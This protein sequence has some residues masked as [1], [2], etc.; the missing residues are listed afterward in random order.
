VVLDDPLRAHA[1]AMWT[2]TFALRSVP[3]RREAQ[4]SEQILLYILRGHV[5][6]EANFTLPSREV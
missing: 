5:P 4:I 1:L 6:S 2:T 3:R